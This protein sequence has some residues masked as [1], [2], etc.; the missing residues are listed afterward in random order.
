ML[1]PSWRG[2]ELLTFRSSTKQPSKSC[3]PELGLREDGAKATRP[4]EAVGRTIQRMKNLEIKT[5]YADLDLVRQ[6]ARSLG[7]QDTRTSRD[8][9]TYFQVPRGRLKLRQTE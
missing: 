5:Y 2:P 6:L 7:A 4:K 8:V 1:A 9:D 3:S